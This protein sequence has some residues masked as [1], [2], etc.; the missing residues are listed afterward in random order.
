MKLNQICPE[1]EIMNTKKLE[2]YCVNKN[3]QNNGD[4]E[5]HKL[6]CSQL[7]KESNRHYL[8]EFNSCKDALIEAK[9]TYPTADGCEHCCPECHKR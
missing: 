8:G 7:P 1:E 3:A 5:V 4:H 9:K 6:T 2:K